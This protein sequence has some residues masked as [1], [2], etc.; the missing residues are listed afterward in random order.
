MKSAVIGLG[1]N[2]LLAGCAAAGPENMALLPQ[3]DDHKAIALGECYAA[4][5]TSSEQPKSDDCGSVYSIAVQSAK[6]IAACQRSSSE[7]LLDKIAGNQQRFSRALL[8]GTTN[9]CFTSQDVTRLLKLTRST[10]IQ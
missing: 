9:G 5:H 7:Q 4:L 3:P 1:M 10:P 8:K 2:A 6:A